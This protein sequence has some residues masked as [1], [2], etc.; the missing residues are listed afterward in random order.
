MENGK[1]WGNN[2]QIKGTKCPLNTQKDIQTHMG[3]GV[4]THLFEYNFS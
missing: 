3:S 2:S 4:V 1:G